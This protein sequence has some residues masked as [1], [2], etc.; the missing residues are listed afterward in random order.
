VDLTSGWRRVRWDSASGG[1]RLVS[2]DKGAKASYRFEG[3]SIGIVAAY[4]GSFGTATVRI[5][6]K[7]AATIDLGRTP[8]AT[9]RI[10]WTKRLSPGRHII[11]VQVRS[12]TVILDAFV[13]T[14]STSGDRR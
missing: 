11:S 3:E 7:V 14:R 1:Y 4:A 9:R 13:V 5:D 12:G 2:S 10:V 8:S 6:G